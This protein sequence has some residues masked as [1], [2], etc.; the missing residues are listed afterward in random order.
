[1]PSRQVTPYIRNKVHE[2]N[3]I[4]PYERQSSTGAGASIARSIIPAA[5]TAIAGPQAGA[6]ALAAQETAIGAYNTARNVAEGVRD[7]V[8]AGREVGETIS[9]WLPS[10]SN[11]DPAP[12]SKRKRP[13]PESDNTSET[14]SER[15]SDHPDVPNMGRDGYGI[16]G[17]GMPKGQETQLT[18]RPGPY[19]IWVPETHTMTHK[20]NREWYQYVTSTVSN[21]IYTPGVHDM[22]DML[23]AVKKPRAFLTSMTGTGTPTIDKTYVSQWQWAEAIW[24]FYS[25]LETRLVIDITSFGPLSR[26]FSDDSGV[27]TYD[28]SGIE[29]DMT[30]YGIEYGTD[31]ALDRHGTALSTAACENMS[32][33]RMIETY[34]HIDE[35][36][37][38]DVY[39]RQQ[40]VIIRKTFNDQ[41]YA[42]MVMNIAN[43]AQNTIW[44]HNTADPPLPYNYRLMPRYHNYA[45]ATVTDQKWYWKIKM[46]VEFD[47]QWKEL[48]Q[49]LASGYYGD[50][51]LAYVP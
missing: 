1:M 19:P 36:M 10:G 27:T 32:R 4:S 50:P 38:Q 30:T 15:Q 5:T 31:T 22:I 35:P 34:D 11:S 21:A 29:P 49:P 17:F 12:G 41:T 8:S 7:V 51:T 13:N 37:A 40:R 20:V 24:N 16:R 18:P 33:V 44:T 45:K 14:P 48:S 25:V 47:V 28:A 39:N 9:N 6:A 26:H 3:Q 43:D 46:Y 23:F 2:R 42:N